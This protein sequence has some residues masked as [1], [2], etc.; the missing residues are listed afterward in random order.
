LY[1]LSGPYV[2]FTDFTHII[3]L[4][5]RTGAATDLGAYN[6]DASAVADGGVIALNSEDAAG[7]VQVVTMR[8]AALPELRC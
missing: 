1:A 3:A 7:N 6:A 5:T 2:I 8:A 4:D